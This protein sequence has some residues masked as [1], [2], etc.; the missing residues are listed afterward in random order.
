M[1]F[2]SEIIQE[3]TMNEIRNFTETG[4]RSKLFNQ[5]VAALPYDTNEIA[6]P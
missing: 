1:N 5:I 6:D 2:S 4:Y 3:A